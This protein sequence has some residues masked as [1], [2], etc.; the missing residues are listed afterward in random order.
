[1]KKIM[2][3]CTILL[4]C[5]A[6]S[7]SSDNE[8]TQ[9]ESETSDVEEVEVAEKEVSENFYV[10]ATSGLKLREKPNGEK[11]MTI[12]YRAEVERLGTK[13]FG[14]L[15]VN[16]L[17]GFKIKGE[18]VKVHY[19]GKDGYVFNGFL[20]KYKMPKQIED[21]DYEKYSSK[22]D[23]YLTTSYDK[24][25]D[26]YDVEKRDDCEDDNPMY[27][28]NSYTQDYQN[29]D[30]K[31]KNGSME[32]GSQEHLTFRNM[33]L[34]EAYFVIKAMD[35]NGARNPKYDVKESINYNKTKN[36]IS[37]EIYDVG[38]ST[39]IKENGKDAIITVSCGC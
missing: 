31:Y 26:K 32:S 10:M 11:I 1:M 33:T 20:T 6:C 30:I 22:F 34:A 37:F 8:V 17:K 15:E 2:F 21:Y 29:G 18:W 28:Y 38:C 3:F 27:C 19:K 5:F 25:G 14:A 7:K 12:P 35:L 9:T 39:D 13:T 24:D 16:E 36:T 23:Y 4:L